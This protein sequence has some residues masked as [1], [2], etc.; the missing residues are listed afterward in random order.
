[1]KFLFVIITMLIGSLPLSALEFEDIPSDFTNIVGYLDVPDTD[2]CKTDEPN[3]EGLFTFVKPSGSPIFCYVLF[4]PKNV[5][6]KNNKAQYSGVYAIT[7][8]Q[9]FTVRV[10]YLDNAACDRDQAKLMRK[11]PVPMEN[12]VLPKP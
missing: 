8:S 10:R 5:N 11:K 4:G 2:H 7:S 6:P 3:C 9:S 1:M 12:V